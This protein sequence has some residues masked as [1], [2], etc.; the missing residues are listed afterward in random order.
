MLKLYALL[1]GLL[2]AASLFAGAPGHAADAALVRTP[3][4]A[5]IR[6]IVQAPGGQG[7]FPAVVLAPGTG[8]LRQR[9]NDVVADALQ[10]EGFVVYRFDWAYYVR[11]SAAAPSDTNR[12]PE[13]EDL[14]T[15]VALAK[16]D[17]RVD[18]SRILVG[19]KSRGTIIAWRVLRRDPS[20]TAILQLTPVCTKAG[21]TPAQLY[22]DIAQ[23]PRPSLWL[24]GDQD[25]A[26]KSPTL[27]QFLSSAADTARIDILRGDHGLAL[28]PS[29]ALA[30]AL[31]VDFAK[32][33][34]AGAP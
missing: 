28:Q 23:E 21:F 32:A 26:C 12:A 30:A 8:S 34:T 14:E 16:A 17:Q 3:R 29:A 1:G 5:A 31:A 18:P 10:N 13:I 9:I 20:L 15:V 22:P 24:A 7:P 25:P 33:A 19:G 6:V 2:V 4:G 27:Y 11:D